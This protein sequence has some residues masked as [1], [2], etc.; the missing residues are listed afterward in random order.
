MSWTVSEAVFIWLEGGSKK[1]PEWGSERKT[2][3][4]WWESNLGTSAFQYWLSYSHSELFDVM[5]ALLIPWQE[6]LARLW[7]GLEYS[8]VWSQ[9]VGFVFVH[10]ARMWLWS[11]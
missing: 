6:T 8:G 11:P 5:S 2:P 10:W 3:C 1:R 4:P 7:C 9:A